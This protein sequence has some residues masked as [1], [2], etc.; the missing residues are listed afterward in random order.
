VLSGHLKKIS[1]LGGKKLTSKK[2]NKILKLNN[3]KRLF[4][5]N[6]VKEMKELYRTDITIGLPE[7]AEKYNVDKVTIHNIMHNKIYVD[8]GG[9]VE[10]RQPKGK[11]IYCGKEAS[12][13]NIS[14][15]HNENCKNKS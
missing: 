12:K 5:E 13:T 8:I 2:L 6:E 3:S 7:L 15:F 14:R 10:I 11:C 1:K 4:T 9:T